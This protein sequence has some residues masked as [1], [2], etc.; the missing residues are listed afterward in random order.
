MMSRSSSIRGSIGTKFRGELMRGT[1]GSKWLMLVGLLLARGSSFSQAD[2]PGG[3]L[4]LSGHPGQAPLTQINGRSYV[5]VDELARLMS[6]AL[7]YQGRQITLTLPT[8][9]SAANSIP[10]ASQPGTAGFSREFLNATIETLSE[11]REWRTALL[12]AVQNG[13]PVTEAWMDDYRAQ[14]AKNLHLTS[15]AA[16]TDSDRNALQLL[17]KEFDHM[18][19]LGNKILTARKRLNYM[20]PDSVKKD[21]LDQKILNCAHS[22]AAMAASG[23]F[24]DNGSC[25]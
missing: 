20:T 2:Q 5:A 7:S 17:S 25:H 4:I 10:L 1:V 6:G 16:T 21:P 9:A 23:N 3:S 14:A 19:E 11:I 13:Y 8:G 24:Q 22:I 12:S 15:I 18:Q